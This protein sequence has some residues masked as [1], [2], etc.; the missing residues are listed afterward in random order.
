MEKQCEYL[1]EIMTEDP[2]P[3]VSSLF[4]FHSK[5]Q[6]DLRNAHEKYGRWL[7]EIFVSDVV[8][9]SINEQL[10]AGGYAIRY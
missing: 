6:N 10:V 2:T 7:G 5:N 3:N 8:N 9:L 1:K 4:A